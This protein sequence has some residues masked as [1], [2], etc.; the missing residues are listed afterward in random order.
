MF[1]NPNKIIRETPQ[2][3]ARKLLRL[4]ECKPLAEQ[5]EIIYSLLKFKYPSKHIHG[6]PVKREKPVDAITVP[7]YPPSTQD[8]T[9]PDY[10]TGKGIF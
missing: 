2:D 1:F 8:L 5:D 3:E 7:Y 9:E 4:I 10:L 6:N